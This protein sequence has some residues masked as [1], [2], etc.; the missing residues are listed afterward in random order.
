MSCQRVVATY[1]RVPPVWGLGDGIVETVVTGDDVSRLKPDPEVYLRALDLLGLSPQNAL[2]I[3]DSALGLRASTAAGLATI[4]VSNDYTADDDFTGAA[5][6]RRGFD[7]VDPLVA[8]SCLRT[9]RH[10]W[11][12]CGPDPVVPRL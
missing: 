11:G 4:V 12:R 3:E 1:P 7:G 5:L 2:A 9:H 8:S 6:V 10:W